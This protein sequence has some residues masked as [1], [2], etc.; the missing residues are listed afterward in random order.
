MEQ[1]DEEVDQDVLD[2]IRIQQAIKESMGDAIGGLPSANAGP[3]EPEA[4]GEPPPVARHKPPAILTTTTTDGAVT[5]VATIPTT[6]RSGGI[7]ATARTGGGM[8]HR[9]GLLSYR[10]FF[11]KDAANA[12]VT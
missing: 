4:D 5:S 7:N 11:S 1:V 8:S 12:P 10:G 6:S 9:G 2:S 3:A